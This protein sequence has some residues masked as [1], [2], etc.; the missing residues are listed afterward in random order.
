ME[1]IVFLGAGGLA[2]EALEV[3]KQANRE[4]MTSKRE[5]LGFIDEDPK[6]H[7]TLLNGYPILGDFDWFSTIDTTDMRAVC[8]I[9]NNEARAK[10]TKKAENLG[11]KFTN[12]IHPNAQMSEFVRLGKGIIVCAGNILTCNIEI[13]NHVYINL[14]CTIGHDSMLEDY[15]N[16]SPGVHVSG[17]CKLLEGSHVFTGAVIA[18]GITIG[19]WSIIG[20][21]AVVLKDIPDY[22]VAV[23]VP[24]KVIKHRKS[25][26]VES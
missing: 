12:V 6:K 24:A 7:G 8:A 17:N 2:R 14:D 4:T 20:A 10:V 11:I 15:V 22:T 18:P 19:K 21:G 5:I 16:L 13:G 1:K 25:E 9:G 26:N 23:G 3:I